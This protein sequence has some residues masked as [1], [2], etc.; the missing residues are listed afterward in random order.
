MTLDLL[1]PTWRKSSRAA[2]SLLAL[3]GG[4]IG[5][6]LVGC[7]DGSSGTDG[8]SAGTESG[9]GG[10]G[11]GAAG[12][13]ADCEAELDRLVNNCVTAGSDS[14]ACFYEEYK[15]FCTSGEPEAITESV[16]CFPDNCWTFADAN[17]AYD[18]LTASYSAH[19]K[20]KA[21]AVINAICAKCPGE[22]VC[23]GEY[24]GLPPEH[25]PDDLLDTI[26]AC[27]D[28]A[29]DCQTARGCSEDNV[30]DLVACF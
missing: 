9:A 22:T 6:S 19:P 3:M 10:S 12:A 27:V 25:L 17:T 16:K 29:A 23:N 26:L 28:A 1:N 24:T 14:R 18:C 2:L 13:V 21:T 4:L 8:G 5:A 20:E 11:G 7:D 30:P 15:A